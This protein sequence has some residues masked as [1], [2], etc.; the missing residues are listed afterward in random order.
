[1]TTDEMQLLRDFRK[2]VPPP[3]EE[4]MRRAYAYATSGLRTGWRQ[5][6]RFSFVPPLR[7][8]FA[9][10]AAAAIGAAAACAVIFTGALGGSSTHSGERVGNLSGS[11]GQGSAGK[12]GGPL[13]F[14]PLT[15][16]F[17]RSDQGITSIA[18][19]INAATLGGTAELQVVRGQIDAP[20]DALPSQVVYQEQIPMKDVSPA[21]SGP[22]GNV[23]LSTWSGTLSPND[24]AGGCQSGPYE[25]TVKVSPAH[26]TT[27]AQGES[28]LSGSFSCSSSSG[29]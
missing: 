16:N 29:G 20:Q 22:P 10:P 21:P 27:E 26:P 17:T 14:N 7:L 18:V 6:L 9:L 24:W 5:S 11:G 28:V 8:R 15:L 3:D 2:E 4:T 12:S 25:I 19:T 23:V 13:Q 1:M